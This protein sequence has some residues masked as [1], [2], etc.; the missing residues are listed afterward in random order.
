MTD[1]ARHNRPD[2]L[3]IYVHWP[4][5][6]SKCPYC[7]F[8][9]HVARTPVDTAAYTD[10]LVRELEDFSGRLPGRI[11]GSVFFGGGT[12]SLMPP[13]CVAR[14]IE[15]IADLWPV[16]ENAEL[17]LEANPTSIEAEKFASL[18]SAG[19]NRV[20]VGI[21]ALNDADLKRLGR[22]HSVDEALG[23]FELA[24]RIFARTSF[25]LIYARPGQTPDDW[26]GELEKALSYQTGHM[27][28][29]Q[30]TIEK[31]TAY[32][33]LHEA[34]KL[35][36]PAEDDAIRLYDITA[37]M[38]AGAGLEAY[39]IS[40]YAAPGQQSRHNLNYWLYGEY[41]GIGP[42]AHS[43]YIDGSRKRIARAN[44][45]DPA[46]WLA[47]VQETGHAALE[48][49]TLKLDDQ[50]RE[51]MLM[52]LRLKQGVS[53]VRLE[54]EFNFV[55]DKPRLDELCRQHLT[56]LSANG[57]TLAATAHGTRLLNAVLACL[58][59]G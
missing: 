2:K 21:Q 17:T 19:I 47:Q 54:R 3:G 39:E 36:M 27:S 48:T 10:A 56:R 45:R 38:T 1:T 52:G 46:R 9:S 30:L 57:K 29:Y 25:D 8:N 37:E 16:A 26:A 53:L 34:G 18:A 14:I 44:E 43:R 40:N 7:D 28:L 12:P 35:K 4:F 23:A 42:G 5:C 33:R 20:S 51:Y 11:V 15:K 59:N 6:L 58:L 55:P 24:S 32:G 50:A 49:E 22:Q 13:S 41:A 31:G